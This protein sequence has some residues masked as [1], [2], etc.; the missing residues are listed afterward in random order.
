MVFPGFPLFQECQVFPLDLV[1]MCQNQWKSVKISENP[2][3]IQFCWNV[4][5]KPDTL[6]CDFFRRISWKT[7]EFWLFHG[8]W[9]GVFW[10]FSVFSGP[11]CQ[12]WSWW[13]QNGQKPHFPWGLDRGFRQNG[14]KQWFFVKNSGFSWFCPKFTFHRVWL[15]VLSQKC[16]KFD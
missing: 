8:D 15:G 16:Q 11:W 13:C 2:V 12:Y 5:D 7:D 3:F 6:R 1:K 4:T 10:H 9:I 14:R